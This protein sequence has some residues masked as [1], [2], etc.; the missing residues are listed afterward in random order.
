MPTPPK[1]FRV[2]QE[3]GKSHRTKEEM[4]LREEGEKALLSN[5]KMKER[6]EVKNNK[7]AHK[8]FLR[9]R[10]LLTEIEKNDALYEAVINRYCLMQ[11]ECLE[12]EEK[13]EYLYGLIKNLQAG[14]ENTIK[15]SKSEKKEQLLL[16]FAKE[17]SRMTASANAIEKAVQ[18]KRKA[19]LELEKENAMTIAAALRMV[20]KKVEKEENDPVV[21]ALGG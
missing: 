9:I 3:E 15:N 14:F 12:L 21:K 17:M 19:L 1:P 20:P 2:L 18:A 6:P 10:K 16:E 4:R 13:R 8:E 5:T 7:E 11:A